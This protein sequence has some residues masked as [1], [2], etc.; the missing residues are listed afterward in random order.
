MD[1]RLRPIFFERHAGHFLICNECK[2]AVRSV[3]DHVSHVDEIEDAPDRRCIE[4]IVGSTQNGLC[5]QL[6]IVVVLGEQ[7]SRVLCKPL[8]WMPV[9]VAFGG[10]HAAAVAEARHPDHRPFDRRERGS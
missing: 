10:V 2:R 7:T 9:L 1:F 3:P 5:H 8:Q 4:G 6:A